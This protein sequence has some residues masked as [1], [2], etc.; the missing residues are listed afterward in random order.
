MSRRESCEEGIE[1]FVAGADVEDLIVCD[2]SDVYE[3]LRAS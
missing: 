3:S 2:R 1:L